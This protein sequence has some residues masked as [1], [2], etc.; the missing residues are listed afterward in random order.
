ML[1]ITKEVL[2]AVQ[3]EVQEEEEEEEV[4][5]EGRVLLEA[6]MEGQEV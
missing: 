3:M 5:Q 4:E 6:Q 1:E 2:E